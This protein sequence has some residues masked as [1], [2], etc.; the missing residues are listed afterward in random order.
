MVTFEGG[1]EYTFISKESQSDYSIVTSPAIPEPLR[2]V[3][4]K[5]KFQE[6]P[7][8]EFGINGCFIEDLLTIVIGRLEEYQRGGFPC[9]ENEYAIYFCVQALIMLNKR[10]DER[11][12][13]GVEGLNIA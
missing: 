5:I 4:A 11:K 9:R 13:R 10:T 6:G 7:V 3:F 8:K 1:T 12:K 2:T